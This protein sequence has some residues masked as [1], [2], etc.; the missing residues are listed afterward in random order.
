MKDDNECG[1]IVLNGKFSKLDIKPVNMSNKKIEEP[2]YIYKII[3]Y[4]L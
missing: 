2:D 3:I 1:Q 4:R